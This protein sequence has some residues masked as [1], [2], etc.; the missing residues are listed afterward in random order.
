MLIFKSLY[1][2]HKPSSIYSKQKKHNSTVER[3]LG[4][5]PVLWADF[6]TGKKIDKHA[7]MILKL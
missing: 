3:V 4:D 7:G 2:N 1:Q 6:E 5:L